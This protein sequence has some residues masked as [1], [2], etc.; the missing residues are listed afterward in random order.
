[1]KY[2]PNISDYFRNMSGYSLLSPFCSGRPSLP[3]GHDDHNRLPDFFLGNHPN[4]SIAVNSNRPSGEGG[5]VSRVVHALDVV[6]GVCCPGVFRIKC[7][8]HLRY[9]ASNIAFSSC[10]TFVCSHDDQQEVMG[11]VQ[12]GIPYGFRYTLL[13]GPI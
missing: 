12:Y 1:M 7:R 10:R 8:S 9:A 6:C 4:M 2:Y 13:Q 3:D 11:V 5:A